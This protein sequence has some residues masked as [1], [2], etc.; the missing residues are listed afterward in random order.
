MKR[1]NRTPTWAFHIYGQGRCLSGSVEAETREA[2][3]R[4]VR[5]L[6]RSKKLW[7]AFSN[8]EDLV[9]EEIG[10]KYLHFQDLPSFSSKVRYRV[11]VEDRS[12]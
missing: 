8:A 1:A 11:E 10:T 4:I 12:W 7:V 2:A 9:G 3:I 5:K 6:V